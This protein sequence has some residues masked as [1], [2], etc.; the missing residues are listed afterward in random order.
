VT[1]SDEIR[2]RLI[3]AVKRRGCVDELVAVVMPVNK[4]LAELGSD[5]PYIAVK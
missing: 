3:Q 1:S 4:M 2:E 5:M